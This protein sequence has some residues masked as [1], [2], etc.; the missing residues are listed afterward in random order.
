[1]TLPMGC[2][3]SRSFRRKLPKPSVNPDARDVRAHAGDPLRAQTLE[4]NRKWRNEYLRWGRSTMGFGFY[5]F[6][7]PKDTP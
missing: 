1:M 7:K 6:A 4:R 2:H 5:L 3:N